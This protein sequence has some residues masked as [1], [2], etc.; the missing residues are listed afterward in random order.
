MIKTVIFDIDGTMYSYQ[1]SNKIAL[2][3]LG[4]F[5][6]NHLGWDAETFDRLFK[7]AQ[8]LVKKRVNMDCCVNHNR[9]IRFQC[10][11]EL[12]RKPLF[13]Y[14]IEMYHCYWDS[15]LNAMKPEPGLLKFIKYI[16]GKGIKIGIGTDMTSYIQY[17]KLERLSVLPWISWIVSSEEAGVEKPGSKFFQLCLEKAATAPDECLFIGDHLEKDVL[18]PV[19]QGMKAAWYHSGQHSD[20]NDYRVIHSYLACIDKPEFFI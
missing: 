16:A 15:F 17:Q 19:S 1:H 2:Q 12:E 7:Q 13:P 11:L 9:L 3:E 20:N 5:C 14:A 4:V 8:Q 6:L 10:M 18:G